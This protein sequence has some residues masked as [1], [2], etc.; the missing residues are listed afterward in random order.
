[1]PIKCLSCGY[2]CLAPSSPELSP[3]GIHPRTEPRT[4]QAAS[5]AG[6]AVVIVEKPFKPVQIVNLREERREEV[7]RYKQPV[8]QAAFEHANSTSLF[9]EA[10]VMSMQT[11][12]GLEAIKS[13]Y[14]YI[15]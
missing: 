1:M 9:L 10:E 6:E 11:L 2:S 15:F 3:P 5:E 4:R 7:L 14:I 13:R 8:W 12:T